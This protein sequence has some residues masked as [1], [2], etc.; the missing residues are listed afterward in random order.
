[1]P[2]WITGQPYGSRIRHEKRKIQFAKRSG[3]GPNAVLTAVTIRQL[4]AEPT[5]VNSRFARLSTNTYWVSVILVLSPG[6]RTVPMGATL[7][8]SRVALKLV[9]VSADP[10]RF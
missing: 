2:K 3:K 9:N 7:P 5:G 4:E 10:V 8:T 1:M 6:S